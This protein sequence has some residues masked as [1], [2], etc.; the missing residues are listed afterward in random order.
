MITTF[1]GLRDCKISD[2]MYRTEDG[3]PYISLSSF[4][5]VLML[6]DDPMY[7]L[8]CE[9]KWE[10]LSDWIGAD[11][12]AGLRKL[13]MTSAA[14]LKNARDPEGIYKAMPTE[15]R[16]KYVINYGHSFY[17]E[18]EEVILPPK[19]ET[20]IHEGQLV[21]ADFI[22]VVCVPPR[23]LPAFA[24]EV[25]F[26]WDTAAQAA[27]LN[28]R[29]R[30]RAISGQ[31]V[32]MQVH[33]LETLPQ[34]ALRLP[35][36]P[37]PMANALGLSGVSMLDRPA[38]KPFSKPRKKPR[39]EEPAAHVSPAPVASRDRNDENENGEFNGFHRVLR[40]LL[41]SFSSHGYIGWDR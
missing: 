30:P 24:T 11:V 19:F 1:L 40:R 23:P 32:M 21:V 36:Q 41:L 22:R 18:D 12:H 28:S 7:D 27:T 35:L 29:A 20:S 33:I 2:S 13:G 5:K 15:V 9:R 39:L 26:S 17:G 16:S 14:L 25:T 3:Y 8:Q 4:E 38:M 31:W 34:A 10:R 37:Y 6:V